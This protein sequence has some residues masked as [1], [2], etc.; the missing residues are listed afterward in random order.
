MAEHGRAW[1]K[2]AEH[3]RKWPSM[4]ESGREWTVTATARDA[5]AD[6]PIRARGLRM[7]FRGE[8]SRGRS[9]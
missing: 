1:P 7:G 3:G 6:F 4:A 2:V 8:E 9:C 5:V